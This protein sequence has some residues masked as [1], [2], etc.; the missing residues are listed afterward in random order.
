MSAP[1]RRPARVSASPQGYIATR[2]T[3]PRSA[4]AAPRLRVNLN[5]WS[6]SS[7]AP[8][9]W[10]GETHVYPLSRLASCRR[11]RSGCDLHAVDAPYK[12]PS[13]PRGVISTLAISR[14]LLRP[15]AVLTCKSDLMDAATI[16]S[17]VAR[18]SKSATVRFRPPVTATSAAPFVAFLSASRAARCLCVPCVFERRHYCVRRKPRRGR[19]KREKID[20]PRQSSSAF[21]ANFF[22]LCPRADRKSGLRFLFPRKPR[23]HRPQAAAMPPQTPIRFLSRR[24]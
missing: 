21:S 22:Q 9:E 13:S 11:S 19:V 7:R 24:C 16:A 18:C 15:S 4:I 2:I 14:G 23:N 5:S 1:R 6:I 20:G 10:A 3:A 8:F 12:R 17:I